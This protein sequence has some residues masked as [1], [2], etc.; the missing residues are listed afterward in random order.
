MLLITCLPVPISITPV[1]ATQ[2]RMPRGYTWGMPENFIPKG[3]ILAAQVAPFV[4]TTSTSAPLMVHALLVANNEI[5]HVAPPIMS[6]MPVINDEFYHPAPPPSESLG[7]YDRMD[8]F[9]D[10]FNEM[11]KEVKDLRGKELL[12]YNVSDFC[13]VPN[14]KVPAKFKVPEFE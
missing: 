12:G 8:D 7:F 11:Q 9:Q 5:H 13:L 2:Y 14:V 6:V 1:T 3:Q 4:P 10:Q